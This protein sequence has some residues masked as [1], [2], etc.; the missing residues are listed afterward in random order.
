MS[1]LPLPH[2]RL[3]LSPQLR[4]KPRVFSCLLAVAAI[5]LCFGPQS[6]LAVDYYWDT[7][8]AT[9]GSGAA[10][11]TWGTDTFWTTDSAGTIGT[12]AYSGDNTSD[13]FFSA[14][15][16]GTTGTVT[17]LGTQ[18]AHSIT[19]R[20][21]VDLTLS[22]GTALNLGSATAGSGIFVTANAANT[23]STPVI[24]NSAAS[25]IGFS[26]SGTGLLTIGAVTGAATSGTQTIAV[27]SS[28]SGDITLNG[29]IGDG[30][31][32]GNV[33]LAVNS[34]GSGITSLS[35]NNTYTGGTTLNGGTLG[36]TQDADLSTGTL[37]LN[38]GTLVNTGAATATST[39]AITAGGDIAFVA[40]TGAGTN[41]TLALT[42]PITLT[43]DRIFTFDGG[44]NTNLGGAITGNHSLTIAGSGQVSMNG[45]QGIKTYTGG[46][47]LNSGKLSI[48]GSGLILPSGGD[49]TING[50]VFRTSFGVNIGS[51]A[52]TL[53]G[54]TIEAMTAPFAD[55]GITASSYSLESGIVNAALLG[56]GA[57]TKSTG[58]TVEMNA[59]S[60]SSGN[61]SLTDGVL[62]LGGVQ[63]D[64]SN[65]SITTI[66]G[67]TTITVADGSLLAIG[68]GI[69]GTGVGSNSYVQTIVGNVITVNKNS[70]ASGSVTGTFAKGGVLGKSG[71]ISFSGGTLQSSAAN[72]YDYSSRFSTAASQTY[73][74]DTNGQN[75]TF[76]SNLTSSGGSL[77]KLGA[78]TLTLSGTNTYTGAT[79]VTLGTLLING[80]TASGS[81]VAVNGGTLGGSGTVNGSVTVGSGGALSPGNSPGI[82]NTG[83]LS[84]AGEFVVEID[85]A[86]VGTQYDQVNVSGTVDLVSGNTL[87]LALNYTPIIGTNFFLIN[88]DVSDA[89][90]GL[91]AGHAQDALFSLSGQQWKIGYTGD[92]AT[93]AFTG[94]NDLVLQAV[95][96]PTT[97]MLLAGSL[98]LVMTC[99]RRRR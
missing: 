28:G 78:G 92:S 57:M 95:P 48:T 16:N 97:W 71:T 90:T 8:G 22:G 4:K 39:N 72:Q 98:T 99:R 77:N 31:G 43:G 84:L 55:R 91:L 20:N 64:L 40:T 53:S 44:G 21:P 19:F 49:L 45:T 13:I 67:S 38:S 96:E 33:A 68:Q 30:A 93:D 12:S 24:L 70:T 17:V 14:G 2:L 15:T 1:Y 83:S 7:N 87:S 9:A 81:A 51:G 32:G 41:G 27:G 59:F 56:S 82:L 29:I 36:F 11:G 52:L 34:S 23:M 94:G 26:N 63:L 18:S 85:G 76:A 50:G 5:V 42:G 47:I 58:G 6:A 10:T 79:T 25:A 37:T 62:S 61:I 54:G 74:I 65:Q 73:K 69:T 86:T 88:N 66:N 89:I 75:V 80:S 3:S 60:S 46:T 35:G